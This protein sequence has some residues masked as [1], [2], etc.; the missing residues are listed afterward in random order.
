MLRLIVLALI[1]CAAVV[2][3]A[4][5]RA[6]NPPPPGARLP[7]RDSGPAQRLEATPGTIEGVVTS[8]ETGAPLRRVNVTALHVD[9]GGDMP[10][11][12]V[13]GRERS[14]IT[15]DR[16]RFFLDGLAAGRWRITASKAGYLTQQVGQ[17]R[18][19]ETPP[20]IT[21]GD[22]QRLPL[23]I[24]LP[25]AGAINGR[26]YD[27]YGDPVA[28]AR[29]QLFRTRMVR[30]QRQLEPIGQ[31]DL[32]DD[33]GAFRLHGL[34]PG[35][36][37]VSA[38][39]RVAP[40]DSVV[41]T[42]HAP[43][44]YPGTGSFAEAQRVFVGKAAEVH[45]D[46]PVRPVRTARITGFVQ[47]S[48]GAPASAFL[49]L[50]SEATELGGALGI[51]AATRDEGS[52]LIPDVPPGVYTLYA[53]LRG[54]GIDSEAAA[55]PLTVYE[56]D[57][58]GV[59]LALAK[60]GSMRVM[61]VPE[62]GVSR[63]MPTSVDLVA[64]SQRAGMETKHGVAGRVSSLPM[65]VPSGPFRLDPQIPEGWALKAIVVGN[66]DVTDAP[67]DL[68]GQQDVAGRLILTD[69]V[70]T[71]I[72]TV[73]HD[74]DPRNVSVV[75]FPE[76]SARW[77]PLSRFTRTT[78]VDQRGGFRLTGLPGGVRYLAVAVDGLEEGEGDDP[79][80]LTRIRGQSISF[81]LADGEERILG[82]AV[83]ER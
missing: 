12:Y 30:K 14:V 20:P 82:L 17:R 8:A 2:A 67:I 18:T 13:P 27:Q 46:F 69:K 15:D 65:T 75:V 80:F 68:K 9:R 74:R 57:V 16:G 19:F 72:G 53:S 10:L 48:S 29:I 83:T 55:V 78:T 49:N 39:L 26:V 28:G 3:P 31:G 35:E 61:L 37:Y 62:A 81:P 64:R 4:G 36:Y 7:P 79:D 33:T 51:G 60:P 66:V 45:I 5:A 70:T 54:G 32:S 41:Q 73:S 40:L 38:S 58:S 25:R 21:L 59:S 44:Y 43:T 56:E 63:V 23:G 22:G 42:T 47:D 24:S 11:R 6:Q 71:V 34:A 52:F 50:M 77:G 76:D 1:G